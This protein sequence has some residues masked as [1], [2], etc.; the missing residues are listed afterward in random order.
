V[1]TGSDPKGDTVN[2][3]LAILTAAIDPI[4][5]SPPKCDYEGGREVYMVGNE[6]QLP[7]KSVEEI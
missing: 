3:I 1:K 2:H 4:C 6:E 5:L 7:D